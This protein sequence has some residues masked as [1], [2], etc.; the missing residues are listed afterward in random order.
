MNALKEAQKVFPSI[1]KKK[2]R[3][4]LKTEEIPGYKEVKEGLKR[5]EEGKHSEAMTFYE[6]GGELG[7]K[8]AFL[9]MGNCYMF[10]K[11]VEQDKKKGIE[12]Y[13]KCV[14]ID[15][16]DELRWMRELSNDRYV[17]GTE[18]DLYRRTSLFS[19]I[20]KRAIP[21]CESFEWVD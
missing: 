5:D 20:D 6:K 4:M 8:A 14:Q 19:M 9:N 1:I 13:G 21:L 15:D 11:G 2:P 7:N 17:F 16:D 3:R 10:G 12:M 18:L